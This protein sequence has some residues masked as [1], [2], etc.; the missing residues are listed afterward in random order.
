MISIKHV[1]DKFVVKR[2]TLADSYDQ[3]VLDTYGYSSSEYYQSYRD[4]YHGSDSWLSYTYNV[5][6]LAPYIKDA[7]VIQKITQD[8]S[9][10]PVYLNEK[11]LTELLLRKREGI[12]KGY[13]EL[14]NYYR[15]YLG[16]PELV[17]DDNGRLVINEKEVFYCP[18]AVSGVDISK[19][20][21][22]FNSNERKLYAISGELAILKK[23]HPDVAYL[24]WI[25]KDISII[26]MRDTTEFGVMWYDTSDDDMI[27][28]AEHYRA[29]RNKFMAASYS[30]YDALTYEFYEPLMCV[31]LIM[32]AV[33]DYN[34]T[35]PISKL[36]SDKLSER[37]IHNILQSFGVPKFDFSVKYLNKLVSR[38]HML[39]YK[40]GSK[41]VLTEISKLFD[42]I[43]IYKYFIVKKLSNGGKDDVSNKNPDDK[44]ELAFIKTPLDVDDPYPYMTDV[45]T[46]PYR[47]IVD[48]DPRWGLND[49]DKLDP[50]LKRMSFSY[51]ES[52]YLGLD[53][54]IDL[55]TFSL[56]MGYFYRF[57][58]EHKSIIT[59]IDDIYIDT[60]DVRADVFQILAYL[61][62]LVLRKYQ[63]APD[64]PDTILSVIQMY[65]IRKDIDY[66]RLKLLFR[67]HFKYSKNKS[68]I[69]ELTQLLD[70]KT[71]NMTG[72]LDAFEVNYELI[73]KLY[74]LRRETRNLEDFNM[75]DNT[76]RAITY[77][78]KIPSLYNNHT[79]LE[80]Y[81]VSEYAHGSKYLTRLDEL[82]NSADARGA[83]S[84]EI[85]I[86]INLLKTMVDKLKHKNTLSMLDTSIHIY[87]DL[88]VIEYLTKIINFYK[89]YTQD[90]I[91]KGTIFN[92][93]DLSDNL[94]IL[95]EL[96]ITLDMTFNEYMLLSFLFTANT[97]EVI[98]FMID[99]F[100]ASDIMSSSEVLSIV[101]NDGT[102]QEIIAYSGL[103]E[104]F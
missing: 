102:D 46:V 32:N 42:E 49:V 15:I 28:F 90:I 82:S 45:N 60:V 69:D 78:E 70:T 48:R 13:V 5:H 89:S 84:S 25:D 43:T 55:F 11:D 74:A 40:K 53:N 17:K 75:I 19:P 33:A 93:D 97:R 16:L 44:Y 92:V 12:L 54:K 29:V 39:T 56:E 99:N 27:K 21:H 104:T 50:E 98:S 36:Y 38:I 85:T 62:C 86:I 95:E 20:I 59:K 30:V 81:L 103:L 101:Y 80:N 66:D 22:E 79:N 47:D 26:T 65:S 88:D 76:I 3:M 34:A 52:K 91:D 51:S 9:L 41:A 7:Y 72:V 100:I 58:V 8:N 96:K 4:A 2:N 18:N 61:Q 1:I 71:Y 31:S 87:S 35:L 64:I 37:E 23:E 57:M 10:A 14:N 68:N 77:G 67:E 94:H 6:D 83:I 63:V 24:K 73:K